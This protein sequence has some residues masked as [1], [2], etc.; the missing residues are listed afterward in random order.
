MTRIAVRSFSYFLFSVLS[1]TI[2]AGTGHAQ[3]AI[4]GMF[5]AGHYSGIGVGYGTPPNESGG[6]TALGGTFGIYDNFMP[7]GP[8]RFGGDARV[9]IENSANS[10]SY[11]NK[12]AGFILGPRL[13]IVPP[14]PIPIKPYIQLEF[15]GVGTNNGTSH[16]KSTSFAYQVNGGVDFTL[17]PH[18]DL[19]GEYGA[20]QLTSIGNSNHTLQEF[21]LGLVLRLF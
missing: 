12:I 5:S 15:G 7:F 11:G 19:R 3:T 18:L 14:P 6:M 17:L 16:D 20:G 21:G 1:F 13:E 10:S 4:Y 8:V 9:F 2:F